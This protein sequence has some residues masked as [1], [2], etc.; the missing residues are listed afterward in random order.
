ML[1]LRIR[2]S[3]ERWR[4]RHTWVVKYWQRVNSGNTYKNE[5]L[6]GSPK[7]WNILGSHWIYY[8]DFHFS[9]AAFSKFGKWIIQLIMACKT[10]IQF[11]EHSFD[12]IKAK[13]FKDDFKVHIKDIFWY[14]YL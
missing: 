1:T 8:L 4:S 14:C 2:T 10:A 11:V 12:V 7:F 9:L 5:L 6:L 3:T 13:R